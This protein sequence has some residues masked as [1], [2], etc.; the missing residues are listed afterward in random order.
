VE[1]GEADTALAQLG[2]HEGVFEGDPG[3]VRAGSVIL[4]N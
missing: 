4:N 3:S 1:R 2:D